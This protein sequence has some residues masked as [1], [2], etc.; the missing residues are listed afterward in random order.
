MKTIYYNGPILTLAEPLYQEALMVAD[1]RIQAVGTEASVL[2]LK[3]AQ[4]VMVDLKGRCL[5]PGFI[6]AHSHICAFSSTLETV[7]L[8]GAKSF[9]DLAELLRG[10]IED[11]DLTHGEVVMGFGYD[12]NFLAEKRHP[13]KT[14]LDGVS[15]ANPILITHQS[16]HM[17]VA[18]SAFLA[19]SGIDAQTPDP[20]GGHFGR[21]DDGCELSGLM[22]ETAFFMAAG[23]WGAGTAE[24]NKRRLNKAQE[25]YLR[26]GVTTAQEGMLGRDNDELLR[27]MA[28]QQ[29]LK[30]DIVGYADL[31]NAHD[32][33][34][35][36]PERKIYAQHYRL[37]GYKIILDGSPQGRTAW[38][39]EPYA[40]SN[41]CAYGAYTDEEV[42]QFLLM[43]A[44][45][46]EQVL[47]H[48]NGDAA[49]EQLLTQYE[50]IAQEAAGQIVRPVMIHA[51]TVRQ[52]QLPRLKAL[53]MIPSF[54]VE[55][56]CQWG[57]IHRQNL[58]EERAAR[59][60]PARS[61]IDCGLTITFHQDTPVL[62]PDMLHTIWCAVNRLTASGNLLGGEERI[63][64]LEA[65]RAVTIN[66]AYQYGEEDEK[67]TLEV[68]KLADLVILE[69]DPL[70][71]NALS[72]KDIAVCAT[73]K[74]GET[75]YG[76]HNF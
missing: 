11:N 35:A 64:V 29:S 40:G 53:N 36:H 59:I 10:F 33:L 51:Q 46:G 4:T 1:G 65:L 28:A 70:A 47:A 6:D 74:A 55:H 20:L 73:I 71:V 39:S 38:L 49:S 25:I 43:A 19:L 5:L 66:A 27:Q 75:L 44:Q 67:G 42:Y 41:D 23:K 13:T 18:N 72:I 14:L 56:V 3:D 7:P 34:C 21:L 69:Q 45:E 57:E 37:G 54:F 48:C 9:A 52:D 2:A 63:S 60:S 62:P 61:A 68:G 8:A 22:E 15:I 58:G 24:D 32:L 26:Y 50:R 12:H 16:G 76:S 17:A 31:K 30:I